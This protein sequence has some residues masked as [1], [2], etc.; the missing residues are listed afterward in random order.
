MLSG[1]GAIS[2]LRKD[3]PGFDGWGLGRRMWVGLGMVN[4]WIPA[5]LHAGMTLAALRLV[6]GV[7]DLAY[8]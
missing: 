6:V 3:A 4:H 5:C 2:F 1:Y 7:F 8:Y